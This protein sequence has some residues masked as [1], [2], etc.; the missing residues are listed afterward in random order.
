MKM[1][2]LAYKISKEEKQAKI[3]EVCLGLLN[4]FICVCNKYNLKWFVD[5]GT[6]LG[7]MRDGHMI[8]W[9]DDVDVIMPRDDYDELCRLSLEDINL[10]GH[11]YFFQTSLNDNCF[12]VH[13]KLRDNNTCALT[14]RECC[15]NHNRGMFLDIFPLDYVPK[16]L[17][18]R[19]EIAACVKTIAKHTHQDEKFERTPLFYMLNKVLKDIGEQNKD[20]KCVANAAYWRYDKRIIT[21]PESFYSYSMPMWFEGITVNV[22]I[23]ARGILQK[24]Y[25]ADWRTPKQLPTDHKAF[26]DPFNSFKNYNGCTKQN[27]ENLMK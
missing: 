5:G 17:K 6:L 4:A 2:N 25:G 20:S 8:P 26:V 14:P 12:E 21:F 22:P 13:A 7:T 16:D 18:T 3:K 1:R 23:G 15:G 10:F 9:D 27:F 11:R 19:K 24:W